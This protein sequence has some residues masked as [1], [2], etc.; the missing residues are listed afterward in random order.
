MKKYL[1]LFMGLNCGWLHAQLSRDQFPLDRSFKNGFLYAAPAVGYTY[2]FPEAES[3]RQI[4]DTSFQLRS[5]AE[6]KFGYGLEVG[7]YHSFENPYFFHYLEI[8]LG[9]RSFSGSSE[10]V[11]EKAWNGQRVSNSATIDY[12]INQ[13]KELY[14]VE[15]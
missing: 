2:P 6:G 3:E 15:A 8:G 11:L 7:W 4:L 10:V 12:T 5:R 9:Y 13:L 14:T 1:L